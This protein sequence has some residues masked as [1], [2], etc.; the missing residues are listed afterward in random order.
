MT[1][2]VR[3]ASLV[4]LACASLIGSMVATAALAQTTT[5]KA[6]TAD[7]N[8]YD[9][10]K[11]LVLSPFQID[12]SNDTGYR[13]TNSISGTRLNTPIKDVP[14]PIEII[15]N[16]FIRDTGAQDLRQALAY[17]AGVVLQSQGDFG[18]GVDDL[19]DGAE[20]V[21][22]TKEQTSIKLR[23]FS[24]TESLR[25]G[26]R[27]ASYTDSIAI[28]RVEVVRGP[29][30]LLYG[31]G[32]FGG[33]VN[34]L[35]K[36]PQRRAKYQVRATAGSWDYLR[37]ELD[38][39]GPLGNKMEMAYRLVASTD[40]TKDY[41]E[42]KERKTFFVMPAFSFKPFKDTRVLVDI[43]VGSSERNGIGFL[44]PRASDA[45][46][47][48]AG[49]K[50]T[51]FL[52]TPGRDRRTFR[53]SGPDTYLNEE[54]FNASIEV[55][56]KLGENL[57][58]LIGA[59]STEVKFDRRDVRARLD[60][61]TASPVALRRLVSFQP[62]GLFPRLNVSAALAYI[63]LMADEDVDTDQTR[64]ELNYR[65]KIGKSSH[66][67]LAGMSMLQRIRTQQGSSTKSFPAQTYNWKAVDDFSYFRYDPDNQV[68]VTKNQNMDLKRWDQGAYL[69]YQGKYFR[70][71]LQILGGL[72]HDRADAAT[73]MHD[74]G[75]G[76][77]TSEQR[78]ITGKATKKWSPQ[79]G[80]S[81]ALTNEVSIFALRSTGLT[82]NDDKVDGAGVPFVPTK[83]VSLEAGVKV[84]LFD[85]K[86]S[87]TASV[88]HIKRTDAPQ[89]FWYA[90]APY[91]TTLFDPSRPI[92]YAPYFNNVPYYE[93]IP[94]DNALLKT[95]F[96][97]QY[98]PNV[99]A[100]P[101]YYFYNGGSA[102]NFP[103][104]GAYTPLND[105]SKGFDMQVILT[106]TKSWQIVLGYAHVKRSVT[107]GPKLVKATTYSEFAVYY[108]NAIGPV[109]QY[110]F[111]PANEHFSDPKDTST[112]DRSLGVGLSFDDTPTDTYT[113]WNNYKFE[114][115][116]LKGFFVGTGVRYEGAR[117]YSAGGLTVDGGINYA[118]TNP[119]GTAS[120]AD[121]Y[122]PSRPKYNVDLLLGYGRKIGANYWDLRLNVF[123]LLDDQKLY[124]DIFNAPRSLRVSLG[125]TF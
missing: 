77:V 107:L 57:D 119:A 73:I 53:W 50:E 101:P 47:G 116:A 18:R 64:A 97:S 21:T 117:D 81:Y 122:E 76:A 84:D 45:V 25:R 6:K 24:T 68:P 111:G 100:P 20:G 32:N 3:T 28:E 74:L 92:S 96:D 13:A 14:M 7:T 93:N 15:T 8:S 1:S 102:V 33:I 94:A 59:Q 54:T 83:A 106:P 10:D 113:L 31:I 90:P 115:G 60:R 5:P 118:Y 79:V 99:T 62:Q 39:T 109:G 58:L 95:L 114:E 30:A 124:G 36:E 70:D 49:R 41:T 55:T 34:Y 112:Y 87:G 75:T 125:V 17:S 63:W 80:A 4:S 38:F 51:G 9:P 123:N 2:P 91:R 121:R 23:G 78:G 35:P 29:S 65:F 104:N 120:N 66:N 27:R 56:Q 37:G 72:R 44:S 105:Q 19:D 48:S 11:I 43:E 42:F 67:L 52:P 85:G 61:T 26:F 12:A 71:R 40:E 46:F 110:G 86:I 89:Y 22:G 103:P 69:V 88:Y 16:E 98:A 82:P 108:A